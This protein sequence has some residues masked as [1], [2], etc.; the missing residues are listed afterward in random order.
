VEQSVTQRIC[1]I[2]RASLLDAALGSAHCLIRKPLQ[3]QDPCKEDA[4]HHPRI[5][6]KANEV[7]P[8]IGNDVISEHALDMAPRAGLVAQI[9]LRDA[10]RSLADQPIVR[11]RPTPGRGTEPLR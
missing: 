3:P 1:V 10:G 6:L 11:I 4:R 9:M 7:R 2:G 8:V 5:D